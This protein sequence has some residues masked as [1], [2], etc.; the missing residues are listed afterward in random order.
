MMKTKT[1]AVTIPEM[2]CPGECLG[3]IAQVADMNRQ[4]LLG[5]AYPPG[6]GSK[7]DGDVGMV[8]MRVEGPLKARWREGRKLEKP[9]WVVHG[10]AGL[11]PG[12][13]SGASRH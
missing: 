6:L 2:L 11:I 7:L 10:V 3:R 8:D 1:K 4:S 9:H 12:R 13:L 5:L